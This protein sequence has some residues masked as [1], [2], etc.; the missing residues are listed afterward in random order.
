V[1]LETCTLLM[2]DKALEVVSLHP[3]H[4]LILDKFQIKVI[5]IRRRDDAKYG[6]FI[7]YYRAPELAEDDA[8]TE[9]S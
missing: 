7:N 5:N 2:Q 1:L 3:L 6:R 8:E 4:L 9:K